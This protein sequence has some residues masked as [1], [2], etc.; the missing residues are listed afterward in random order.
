MGTA[1]V[2]VKRTFNNGRFYPPKTKTARRKIDLAPQLLNQLA[3]WKAYCPESRL[4]LVFQNGNGTPIN[5]SNLYNRI[6]IPAIKKAGVTRL[7][8]HTLR[9]LL[10]A[11]SLTRGKTSGIFSAQM[12]H[13]KVSTTLVIY[14]H[15][16]NTENPESDR[17]P[18]NN[19]FLD[20]G[21]KT[22]VNLVEGKSEALKALPVKH[23]PVAQLDRAAD[24]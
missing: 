6:Y 17:R 7:K 1:Q 23:A 13:S 4:N 9:R 2:R 3:E 24:F 14:S 10:P 12:G 18:G 5:A 15:L 20:F 22:V 11:F 16:M 21:S 19:I 8:F